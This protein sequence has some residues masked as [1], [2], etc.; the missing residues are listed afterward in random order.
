MSEARKS[1]ISTESA[2][3]HSCNP[4]FYLIIG[5]LNKRKLELSDRITT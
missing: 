5:S 3:T 1:E 2:A 4:N